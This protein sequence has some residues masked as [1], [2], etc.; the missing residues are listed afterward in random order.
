[1]KKLIILGSLFL[2]GCPTIKKDCTF[3]EYNQVLAKVFNNKPDDQISNKDIVV[4]KNKNILKLKQGETLAQL[5][6]PYG[7]N[8]ADI[9]KIS[10]A[11]TPFIAVN[12]MKV[13]HKIYMSLINSKIKSMEIPITFNQQVRLTKVTNNWLADKIDL[14]TLTSHKLITGNI[15]ESFYQSALD[16]K[17]PIT[18]IN[19]FLLA[20]SHSVDFQRAIRK[21][22]SFRLIY[23]EKSLKDNI[24]VK[25]VDKLKYAELTLSD[26]TTRLY[27]FENDERGDYFYDDEGKLASSFLLKTPLEGARLSSHFGKRKHPA[28]LV[29]LAI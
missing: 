15:S 1:M 28:F 5:L 8:S 20:Y 25:R 21:G 26:K 19:R 6:K 16:T 3:N 10:N 2:F 14:E 11:L 12:K 13:G 4:S 18:V 24:K 9:L 7:V 22:D 23:T 29:H 17:A 27:R